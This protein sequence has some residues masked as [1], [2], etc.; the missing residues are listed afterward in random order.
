MTDRIAVEIALATPDRQA[1]IEVEV[2]SG[3]TVAD[4][5]AASRIGQQFPDLDIDC[6]AAGVWGKVLPRD[7][8][9][10]DGDR[11]E[12]YRPLEADPRDA[13]RR[14]AS[15]GLTMGQAPERRGAKGQD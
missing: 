1:L 14:R 5:I 8:A 2:D 7:H 11:V 4:V 10:R 3:A 15:V 12:L 9:V 6:M 13:R